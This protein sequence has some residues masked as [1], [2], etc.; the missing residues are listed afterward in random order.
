MALMFVRFLLALATLSTA[1][2]RFTV[3]ANADDKDVVVRLDE[4]LYNRALAHAGILESQQPQHGDTITDRLR[5]GDAEALYEVAKSMNDSG[6]KISS[7][8]IW[9]ALADDGSEGDDYETYDSGLEY[10]YEGHVPSALALGFSYYDVDKPRSLHYFLMATS[11]KG[12][13]HQAAMFNAGRLYLELED[14]SGALAYIRE[15]ANLDKGHPAHARPQLSI[16]CRKAYNTLSTELIEN[17]DVGLEEAIECFPYASVDDFPLSN[18][19]EEQVFHGAMEQ[20][21]KYMEVVR[22]NSGEVN[23]SARTKAVKH[24]TAAIETLMKF[25]SSNRGNMSKLQIYLIGYI[26]ERI[27]HLRAQLGVGNGEL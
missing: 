14:P 26:I 13:P 6:D 17:S 15:C 24:L 20:L 1:A 9:H 18:S 4:D 25:T 19:K 10:D 23:N 5:Q 11:K 12:L 21:G 16:S 22:A 3:F 27:E 8:L 2:S 7:V